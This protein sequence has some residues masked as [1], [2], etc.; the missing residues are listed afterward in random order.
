MTLI[1]NTIYLLALMTLFSDIFLVLIFVNYLINSWT[2]LN[3]LGHFT[4][5]ARKH[6]LFLAWIVA[7]TATMGSL[8]FS[9]VAGF[10]PC[11]LC[12][13]Q[14][15]FMY[16]LAI[17]LG[18][19]WY[20]NDLKIKKYIFPLVV[21]GGLIASYHY[22]L[23]LFPEATTLICTVDSPES[24]SFAPFRYFGYITIPMMNLSAN[25]LILVI[26]SL[27]KNYKIR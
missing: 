2:S 1:E 20:I 18:V 8:F 17:L 6:M 27:N 4:D 23:H 22:Y 3:L 25:I 16:P 12:W 19:A 24:C 13:F 26:L 10:E 15:I 14:R 9:E 21:V 11:E 5:I 7:L